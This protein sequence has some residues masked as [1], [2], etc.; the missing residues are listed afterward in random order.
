MLDSCAP[1]SESAPSAAER[2]RL[3]LAASAAPA[4]ATAAAVAGA[5]THARDLR[6]NARREA[7][8]RST[9]LSEVN[10][11][12]FPG[13]TYADSRRIQLEEEGP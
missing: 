7:L 9:R 4:G 8:S 11:V 13:F 2:D 3:A 12:R 5:G 1:A 10:V 6:W